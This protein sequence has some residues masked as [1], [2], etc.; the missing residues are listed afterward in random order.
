MA[1][2]QGQGSRDYRKSWIP[3][4]INFRL[5]DPPLVIVEAQYKYN[6]DK[7]FR[8]GLQGRLSLALVIL[9]TSVVRVTDSPVSRSQSHRG[10]YGVYGIIDQMVSRLPGDDP[11]KGVGVFAFVSASPFGSQCWR[12]S[13]TQAGV[14]FMGLW[15][16]RPEGSV[17]GGSGLFTG[18]AFR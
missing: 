5:R 8:L 11:K 2:P 16:K 15:D 10:D 4:G 18:F 3:A 17:R 6:Q 14:N 13:Y 12:I 7:E 1:I 9:A